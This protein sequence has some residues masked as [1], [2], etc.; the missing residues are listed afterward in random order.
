MTIQNA[1]REARLN[2]NGIIKRSTWT[3][4]I[5]KT[6]PWGTMWETNISTGSERPYFL[7]KSDLL[8]T[9]WIVLGSTLDSVMEGFRSIF[10]KVRRASWNINNHIYSN[11]DMF[12]E[13]GIDS[14]TPYRPTFEDLVASDWERIEESSE[15][16]EE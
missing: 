11:G 13:K 9:D 4:T 5:I 6:G 14:I 7:T 16:E 15:K 8:A 2:R 1:C 12:Y 3:D 10:S